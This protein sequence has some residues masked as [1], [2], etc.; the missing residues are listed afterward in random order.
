MDSVLCFSEE[1]AEKYISAIGKEYI[2][3]QENNDD[4]TVMLYLKDGWERT[5]DGK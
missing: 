3:F 2:H 5:D 1:E 4:G